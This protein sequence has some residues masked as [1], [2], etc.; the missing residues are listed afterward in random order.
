MNWDAIAA[1]AE[2]L[3]A[4]GVIASLVY[5]ARQVRGAG[6]QAR[7]AAVTSLLSKLSSAMEGIHGNREAASIWVRGSRGLSNLADEEE[8]TQF[9]ALMLLVYRP[10]EEAFH[11]RAEGQLDD[12]TWESVRRFADALAAT[13]GFRE[14]WQERRVWF[15]QEFQDHL[16]ATLPG[17]DPYAVV[18]S[19]AS[20]PGSSKEEDAS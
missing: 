10:Y 2:L 19:A 4:L 18:G 3:A 15:S 20:P 16:D 13:N 9:S 17:L 1:V 12:W 11:Y 5:L 7:Q 8:R 6:A 14:W